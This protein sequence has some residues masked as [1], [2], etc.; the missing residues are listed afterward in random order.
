MGDDSDV[1]HMF[2]LLVEE[3]RDAR[4]AR[5]ELSNIYMTLNLAGVA[6][7][8]YIAEDAAHHFK[9]I[10]LGW[11]V[12]A[13]IFM[14]AIW[15]TSN[16]YYRHVLKAKYEIIQAYETRL[17]EHPI[18][19]EWQKVGGRRALRAFTLERAMPILFI[20]GYVVF[21]VIQ[22]TDPAALWD[23]LLQT[24]DRVKAQLHLG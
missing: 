11:G 19:D 13:L 20:I 4:R 8:G 7:L 24:F 3:A 1:F 10:L 9:P 2:R 18:A 6:A 23:G 16:Q 14:C 12:G 22:L 17:N 5:R 15:S 21:F